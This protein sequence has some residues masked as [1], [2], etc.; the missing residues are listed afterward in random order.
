[1][2]EGD[3]VPLASIGFRESAAG[4]E[5]LNGGIADAARDGMAYGGA[6]DEPDGGLD[7][8]LSIIIENEPKSLQTPG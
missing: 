2:H 5:G 4:I 7:Q 1:M 6:C 8:I 3:A